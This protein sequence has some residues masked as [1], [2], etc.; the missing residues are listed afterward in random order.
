LSLPSRVKR[1]MA[2]MR[3]VLLPLTQLSDPC[4][5]L[6]GCYRKSNRKAC[7][8]Q[9]IAF[10]YSLMEAHYTRGHSS[11]SISRRL[12][13]NLAPPTTFEI[14]KFGLESLRLG[15]IMPVKTLINLAC[16]PASSRE[17]IDVCS[18][19]KACWE[20]LTDSSQAPIDKQTDTENLAK[21][22]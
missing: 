3:S 4:S 21:P 6:Q 12:T 10:S 14:G 8:S 5:P 17:V 16:A 1:H 18:K 19:Q 2:M 20:T 15:E 13:T 9:L 7:L 22:F 11:N